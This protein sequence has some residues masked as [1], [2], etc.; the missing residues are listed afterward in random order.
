MW[1]T[2]I[3]M[4]A[5]LGVCHMCGALME[6]KRGYKILSSW[7]YRWGDCEAPDPSA[8]NQ[9][10]HVPLSTEPSLL[11]LSQEFCLYFH[12]LCKAHP[13]IVS[14]ITIICKKKKICHSSE[15]CHRLLMA[16]AWTAT[17]LQAIPSRMFICISSLVNFDIPISQVL[18]R[19]FFLFTCVFPLCEELQF[20]QYCLNVGK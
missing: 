4:R 20:F 16:N 2:Y 18:E 5:Y 19:F 10:Q 9:T 14:N 11:L 15:K 8:E 7:S 1:H 6:T 3:H 13:C 12:W 17:A